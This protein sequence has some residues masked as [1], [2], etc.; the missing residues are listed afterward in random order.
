MI[1]VACGQNPTP[2]TAAPTVAPATSAPQVTVPPVA[3][4]EVP[5]TPAEQVTLSL[6]SWRTLD[7][8]PMQVILDAFHAS[9]PNITVKFD[10]T[11]PTEYDAA[12]TTEL[13]S[14]T[15]D[16]LLY[17]RSLGSAA[18]EQEYEAGYILPIDDL[19]GRDNLIP[20]V[21]SSWTSKDGHLFGVGIYKNS[22]GLFY[23]QDLFTKLNL[24]LPKSW[25]ELLAAAKTIKAAGYAPFANGYGEPAYVRSGFLWNWIPMVIGGQPGRMNYFNG[26]ACLNDSNWVQVFQMLKDIAPYLP[27]G[28]AALGNSDSQQYF[29]QGKAAMY[30]DGSYDITVFEAGKPAFQWSVM[31]IPPLQGHDTYMTAELDAA[32]GINKASKHIPEAKI[33]LSW[34]TSTEFAKLV[35][36]NLT[37]NFPVT[38]DTNILPTDPYALT[39]LQLMSQV[40]GLDSRFYMNGGTPGTST[41]F[42]T[43]LVSVLNG[44]MT[45]QQAAQ[46]LYTGVSTWSVPQQNC[47]K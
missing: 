35:P 23:N 4:T 27:T 25:D 31:P 44:K 8:A 39:F 14:G 24:Q 11:N 16:D 38:K 37:G 18:A 47:K 21:I 45:P 40:K 3:P 6:A 7:V 19:P 1:L 46:D 22:A 2:T 43:E 12:M 13:Q 34:L 33:F 29:M 32:V 20:A 30:F 5:A 42:L 26:T 36:D 15:G 10:P 41:L 17:L 28:A 9:H